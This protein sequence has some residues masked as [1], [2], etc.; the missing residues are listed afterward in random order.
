MALEK[1]SFWAEKIQNGMTKKKNLKN[2]MQ[3]WIEKLGIMKW[4]RSPGKKKG[5]GS[6]YFV[7]RGRRETM[8]EDRL[9]EDTGTTDA[10]INKWKKKKKKR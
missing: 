5:L 7:M 3:M 10:E 4:S 2:Q 1:K 6:D 8:S 9:Y